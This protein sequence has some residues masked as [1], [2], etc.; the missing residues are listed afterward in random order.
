MCILINP[1]TVIESTS[2]AAPVDNIYDSIGSLKIKCKIID[3]SYCLSDH[4]D[5]QLE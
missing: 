5:Y 4:A 2:K 3:S 1:I